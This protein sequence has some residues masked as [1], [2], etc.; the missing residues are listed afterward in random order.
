LGTHCDSNL[1]IV[2][3]TVVLYLYD[4][5]PTSCHT[6]KSSSHHRLWT[7]QKDSQHLQTQRCCSWQTPHCTQSQTCAWQQQKTFHRLKLYPSLQCY[8]KILKIK[9]VLKYT[10]YSSLKT[11]IGTQILVFSSCV[12]VFRLIFVFMLRNFKRMSN[13]SMYR[14]NWVL[15]FWATSSIPSIEIR[16][17]YN[18]KDFVIEFKEN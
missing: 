15:N 5:D 10:K 11:R 13:H 14:L 9:N 18:W 7:L 4:Y 12:N 8:W 1:W 6:H 17:I 16:S 3:R 2:V